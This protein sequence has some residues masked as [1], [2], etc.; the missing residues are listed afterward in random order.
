MQSAIRRR[1]DPHQRPTRK[2][3]MNYV[4]RWQ[5]IERNRL[6]DPKETRATIIHQVHTIL[7]IIIRFSV[8]QWH[9]QRKIYVSM[10]LPCNPNL[11]TYPKWFDTGRTRF[12]NGNTVREIDYFVLRPMDYQSWHL[13]TIIVMANKNPLQIYESI[14]FS[15]IVIAEMSL[16]SFSHRCHENIFVVRHS[17]Y[18]RHNEKS[19]SIQSRETKKLKTTGPYA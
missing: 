7:F 4:V 19:Y 11:P 12:V 8:R 16:V 9:Y 10:H 14:E 6:P 1:C 17:F 15:Q 3:Y 18:T 13:I 5:C 2:I